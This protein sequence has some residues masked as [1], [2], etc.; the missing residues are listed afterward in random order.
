MAVPTNRWPLW[1]ALALL[2]ALSVGIAALSVIQN[3]RMVYA[4]DDA[5]IH[6]SIA[7]NLV[8]HGVWGVT[9]YG[10]S[11]AASSILW[12]LLMAVL[13]LPA[14]GGIIWMPLVVNV[15][16]AA[17]TLLLADRVLRARGAGPV[18]RTCTLLALIVL[19]P[20]IALIAG[21]MEHQLHALLTIAFVTVWAEQIARDDPGPGG[22]RAL[23]YGLA[24]LLAMVRYEGLFTVA[25]VC[26]L[27]VLRR[28]P[29]QALAVA[30][31][32]LAPLVVFGLASIHAGGHALPNSLL[33]KAP[34]LSA[35]PHPLIYLLGYG[36]MVKINSSALMLL[37][38]VTTSLLLAGA[39][40]KS[41]SVFSPLVVMG[42]VLLA[43]ALLH[44]DLAEVG[45]LFRYE[46]YLVELAIVFVGCAAAELGLTLRGL[47]PPA[48]PPGARL[49]TLAFLAI[50]LAFAASPLVDRAWRGAAQGTQSMNDRYLEHVLAAE[51]VARYYN[52]AVVACNDIGA[53]SFYTHARLLDLYGLASREPLEFRHRPGGYTASDVERWAARNRAQI[54]VLQGEWDEIARVIPARWALVGRWRLPRNLIFKD[55]T[56][57]FY[58]VVPSEARS[59]AANQADYSARLPSSIHAEVLAPPR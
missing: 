42:A 43:S 29:L 44:A 25:P 57:G 14:R 26:G 56:V 50:V 35:R 32:A 4:L 1:A 15:L 20:M 51:F 7:R 47:V 8:E 40:R 6:L 36:A 16:A 34:S 33:V 3:G 19:G 39:L 49:A 24:A 12:P 46:A 58:A 41:R 48:T 53:L 52:G 23:G 9:P 30:A 59:L 38:L 18:L 2:A 17:A 45:W 22:Q 27:L 31:A 11:S 37:L 10:F 5:Y 54:A 28:R 13:D 21:G 55:T